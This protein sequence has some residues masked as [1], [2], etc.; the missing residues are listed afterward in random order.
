MF[1]SK[2][3]YLNFFNHYL[4]QYDIGLSVL[5]FLMALILFVSIVK[6]GI[7]LNKIDTKDWK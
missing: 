2:V 4:T 7:E 1:F 3:I 5:I 6:K